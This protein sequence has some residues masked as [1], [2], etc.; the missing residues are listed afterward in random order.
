MHNIKKVD[1]QIKSALNFLSPAKRED[2]MSRGPL[3][4]KIKRDH[5]TPS[6]QHSSK[7]RKITLKVEKNGVVHCL[8]EDYKNKPK[9][10]SKASTRGN[11]IPRQLPKFSQKAT[12]EYTRGLNKPLNFIDR[13]PSKYNRQH[14]ASKTRNTKIQ[15]KPTNKSVQLSLETAPKSD[16]GSKVGIIDSVSVPNKKLEES[17]KLT[18]SFSLDSNRTFTDLKY[19]CTCGK[20]NELSCCKRAANWLKISYRGLYQPEKYKKL[21]FV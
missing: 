5:T 20:D 3:N 19:P 8:N 16:V 1:R 7:S 18:T 2:C 11:I 4:T 6:T 17:K 13:I 21:Y 14:T 9:W 15:Q 12:R 10:T